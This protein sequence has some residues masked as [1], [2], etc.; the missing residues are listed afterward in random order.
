MDGIIGHTHYHRKEVIIVDN[1]SD[2]PGTISLY[3]HLEQ[4]PD[5]R[6]VYYDKQFNYSA[7]CNF[8]ALCA[9]GELLLFLNNDVEVLSTD[10]LA[11]LVR[12]A[13]R[14]GV[15]VVGT[16]LVYPTRA[17]QHAGVVVGIHLCGLVFRNAP[18]NEWGVF[19]SPNHPRNYLAIMG[20]CQ[21]VRREVFA[22]VGRFDESY[23]IAN[24]DVA[25]CLHAWRAGYRIAYTP[26]ASMVHHEGASRGYRTPIQ[27]IQRTAADIRRL[28]LITDDPYFHPELSAG[29]PIPKLRVNGDVSTKE[30][31]QRDIAQYF[32]SA[33]SASELDLYDDQEIQDATGLPLEVLLWSPQRAEAISDSW[34]AARYSIDLLRT[35]F[36]LRLQFRRALSDG[37]ASDF[38]KWI[39]LT[40]GD[41]LLLS[42]EARS[43]IKA[44]FERRLSAR[45]R[46]TL[47]FREELKTNFP[48]GLT[49]VGRRDLFRWFMCHGRTETNLRLEEIWWFFLE[50]AEDPAREL[51]RTYLFTPEW[52]ELHP[53][54]LTVFGQ[55]AFADWLAARFRLTQ[56]WAN[57]DAWP[58]DMTPAQQIRLA[59][60]SH[61]DWQKE[62]P[63]A[64]TTSNGALLQLLERDTVRRR[65][66]ELRCMDI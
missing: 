13:M 40:G 12:F 27:D 10:W 37:A 49:S 16:Q 31:L 53:A 50:S 17:L 5:V 41:E 62:H 56:N 20:A 47:W 38:V 18:I 14:P 25:I 1:A 54:G 35:R 36:D 9:R 64:M 34:S 51:V 15:G 2:D 63:D 39:T 22:R 3:E 61:E 21:L 11:E 52:Q 59:Y 23:Q 6:I 58:L 26:F 44:I 42:E 30:N 29:N 28:G 43:H 45:V 32:C 60:Y 4:H 33:Q 57:P 48:M 7:S 24:S 19:G 46:Q 65:C 66:F 55:R 8:G